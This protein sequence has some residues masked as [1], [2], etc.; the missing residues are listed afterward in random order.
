MIKTKIPYQET[1]YFSKLMSDYLEEKEA[2]KPFYNEFSNLDNFKKTIERR[3]E[4]SLNRTVL[5]EALNQQNVGFDVS[6][7]TQENI[8]KLNNENCYTVTTGHQ[9]NLFTGPL[10][11][12]YKIVSAINLAKELK[13]KFPKNDFVPV[14]W[15]ATEDHDFEEINHFNLFGKKYQLSNAQ[16]GAV[17]NLKLEGVDELFSELKEDL[18]GRNGMEDILSLF[19]KYYKSSNTYAD[20]IR[21]LV[22]D[23][24]GKYG[25]VVIDGD[26]SSLKALMIKEF[27]SELIDREN[28]KLINNSS[29]KLKKIGFKPQ[30]TPREINLFYLREGG[31]ER[32]VFEEGEYKVLNTDIHFSEKA[33]LIELENHPERFSPNAPL[34]CLYQEK[35]LPNLAYIGGGGELAYWFQL[36]EMF[37]ANEISYPML[38]LRNSAL[39]VDKGS[40]KK[41]FKLGLK[42]ADLFTETES[43]IKNYLKNGSDII[44]ELHDEEKS[45]ENI[46]SDIIEKASVIDESLSPMIKAELQK[47]L[48][49]IKNIENRLIKSEKKKEEVGVNQIKSLKDK[50]FPNGSLQ[51]RHDNVISIF[52]FYGIDVIDELINQ[53]DPLDKTFTILTAE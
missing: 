41:V 30:L 52:L 10:Y 28:H 15:M 36:K 38:V 2:L 42:T 53:L 8:Q 19:S 47:S 49:S 7:D 25:L 40:A 11:F 34:R 3:K 32:I 33:I 24:F 48:K 1:G 21:G 39:F 9:L 37:N 13:Q 27:K 43:L 18:G 4:H 44:L 45:I 31:R 50:L 23:L 12:I 51:E 29:D 35:I 22:I 5:V 16:K 14:Y 26:D 17:G 6:K 20:A 46:F